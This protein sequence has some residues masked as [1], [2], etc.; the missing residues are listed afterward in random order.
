MIEIEDDQP[1]NQLKLDSKQRVVREI[2]CTRCRT[3][4]ADEYIFS[5]RLTLICY[6]CKN[7]M[8]ITFKHTKEEIYG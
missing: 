4:L 8:N 7:V 2:R 3:W 5:G 1:R 6:Q